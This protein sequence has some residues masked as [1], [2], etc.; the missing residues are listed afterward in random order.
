MK[1]SNIILPFLFLLFQACST[2]N[3]LETEADESF[4][5]S[6][7][8][9]FNFFEADGIEDPI[10]PA[11]REGMDILKEKIADELQEKGLTISNNPDLL[12]N[13]GVVVE[14][15][16]QT[17]ETN[18]MEAPRYIGQRRYSW[19]SEEVVTNRYRMGTVTLHLV[20]R[21][22]NKLVWRGVA[23]GVI[24]ENNRRLRNRIE[25]GVEDLLSEIR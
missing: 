15:K 13:I 3:V 9:T 24:P 11:Q 16:T 8:K 10:P 12:V 23:E 14:D 6:Q 25:Q 1:I 5:L 4:D 2:V 19:Q 22:E 21:E 7:Y 18:I 20:E 17:R